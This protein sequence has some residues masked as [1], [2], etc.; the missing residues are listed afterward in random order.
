[1]WRLKQGSIYIHNPDYRRNYNGILEKLSLNGL[2][3]KLKK[4]DSVI[5]D[6]TRYNEKTKN[7]IAFLKTFGCKKNS[8]SVFG[9]VA[10]K[11]RTS[12]RVIGSSAITETIEF[13]RLKGIRLAEKLGFEIPPY[14]KFDT[15]PEGKRFLESRKDLW[16]LKPLDNKDLDLTYVENFPGELLRKFEGDYKIRLP[17]KI[18]YILQ[19]KIDGNE[20]STEVWIPG[21]HYNHTLENKHLMDSD[22]SVHI[23]SQSN[24]VWLKKDDFLKP[25]LKKLAKFL[26]S[27]G[28]KGPCD[29]NCIIKNGK[30][31]FLEFTPRFGFDALYGLLTLLKTPLRDFFTK[32]FKGEFYDGY[33]ATERISIPPY[34]YSN[35]RLLL[36]MAKDVFV[37]EPL[38][39]FWAEDV[40]LNNGLRCS[41]SDGIVGVLSARG[42][43]LEEAWGRLYRKLKQFRIAS[44]K[45]YRT[46]GL[47]SHKGRL[48][49]LKN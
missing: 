49:R 39:S 43:N 13:D 28:Y 29:V 23:G 42:G 5:F 26:S 45:Q 3:R 17:D 48:W 38:E 40:Y 32:D 35:K 47:K 8:F 41:G 20:L 9:P 10:D 16:V 33:A 31:Y 15:L 24:S 19:K 27:H 36:N 30:A 18:E 37:K 4:E 2:K 34:P 22:L 46:D 11:L 6:M 14:K 1:L 12:H 25:Q 44:Y 21:G 7:D